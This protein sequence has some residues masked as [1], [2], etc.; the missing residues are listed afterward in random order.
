MPGDHFVA[1]GSRPSSAT[2]TICDLQLNNGDI[3]ISATNTPVPQ[4]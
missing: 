3:R 1:S 4:E 2:A